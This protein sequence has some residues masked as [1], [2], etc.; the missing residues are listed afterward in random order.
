MADLV[1]LRSLQRLP[2]PCAT[3]Q[4][5]PPA[6]D[7]V[8]PSFS[9]RLPPPCAMQCGVPPSAA[10]LG[11]PSYWQRL[12]PPCALQKAVLPAADLGQPSCSHRLPPPCALQ[13][14]V[15]PLTA[16]FVQP[17]RWHSFRFCGM[18]PTRLLVG[19]DQSSSVAVRATAEAAPLCRPTSRKTTSRF[20]QCRVSA[21]ELSDS[22]TQIPPVICVERSPRNPLPNCP[23]QAPPLVA[24]SLIV[25]VLSRA[26]RS[27]SCG[28]RVPQRAAYDSRHRTRLPWRGFAPCHNPHR[29]K[30]PWVGDHAAVVP[31]SPRHVP[32]VCSTSRDCQH[33]CV[34]WGPY[35]TQ[36]SVGV[37]GR[38][39]CCEARTYMPRSSA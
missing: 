1:Q 19:C 32:R 17:P 29:T 37:S 31:A 26:G 18:A 39:S 22:P 30:P 3:Q 14:G 34:R 9:Q 13:C 11:Q 7:L 25:G 15:P 6:A 16:P 23:T 24:R 4:S 28:K 21:A 12:P 38:L 5:E 35:T 2:P 33:R 10:L 36:M 8:Q 20:I 27:A